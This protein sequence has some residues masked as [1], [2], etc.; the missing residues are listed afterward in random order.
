[1]HIGEAGSKAVA[2]RRKCLHR[3]LGEPKRSKE[4]V[5]EQR[6]CDD[7]VSRFGSRTNS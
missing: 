1:M 3:N 5:E 2:G 6:K 4:A 7:T